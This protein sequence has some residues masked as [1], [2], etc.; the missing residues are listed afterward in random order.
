MASH[1]DH[2]HPQELLQHDA[3]PGTTNNHHLDVDPPP[4]LL[5]SRPVPLQPSSSSYSN[6]ILENVTAR[7]V[8]APNPAGA[9]ILELRVVYL[10]DHVTQAT[11]YPVSS[12]EL[13]APSILQSLH[14]ELNQEILR[15]DTYPM[16]EEL[17]FDTF[18]RYWFGVF[19]AVMLLGKPDDHGDLAADRD[20]APYILGSFYV[21]PNY[22][23]ELVFALSA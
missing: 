18:V 5:P 12:P 21:K 13:L 8:P 4:L 6:S 23:G 3:S 10:K 1:P 15:G 2:H 14:R 11:I 20:W 22:P 17:D 7:P 19:A 9:H 16:E